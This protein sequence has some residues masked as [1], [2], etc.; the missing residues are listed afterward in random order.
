MSQGADLAAWASSVKWSDYTLD[1]EVVSLLTQLKSRFEVV[2]GGDGEKR[3]KLVVVG[4]GAVGKTSLLIAFAKGTFPDAYVPTVF[5]NYTASM[6]HNEKPVLLHLWDT[7]GQED[8]VSVAQLNRPLLLSNSN[9]LFFFI[10]LQFYRTGCVL[11]RILGPT[12][13]S[14]VFPW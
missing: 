12:W 14:C 1:D 8:Y 10:V 6:K 11:C 2:Y 7:A 5:E 9:P 3:I 13:F 4:D